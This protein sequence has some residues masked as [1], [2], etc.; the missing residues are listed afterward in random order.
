MVMQIDLFLYRPMFFQVFWIGSTLVRPPDDAL[1]GQPV[2]QRRRRYWAAE[3]FKTPKSAYLVCTVVL[4]T[5]GT[6][7]RIEQPHYIHPVQPPL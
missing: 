1:A 7:G 4:Y 5:S 3:H 2:S 6:V